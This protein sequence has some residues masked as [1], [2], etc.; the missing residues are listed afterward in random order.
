[1]EPFFSS[2]S[3]IV[4]KKKK[5]I[6][7]QCRIWKAWM[8]VSIYNKCKASFIDCRY[9]ART[10]SDTLDCQ[11]TTESR[12]KPTLLTWSV[13]I[14]ET[15]KGTGNLVKYFNQIWSY[16]FFVLFLTDYLAQYQGWNHSVKL[17]IQWKTSSERKWSYF[18]Y[19]FVTGL[20][21][22]FSIGH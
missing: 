5:Q 8:I 16:W 2:K 19:H 7:K 1:M 6:I 13:Q 4:C 12:S 21:T 9:N 14:Y 17:F 20:A 3:C 18:D 11:N 10:I 15:W 22:G